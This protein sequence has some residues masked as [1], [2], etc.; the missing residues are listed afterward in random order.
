VFLGAAWAVLAATAAGEQDLAQVEFVL[1]DVGSDV[2]EGFTVN[3]SALHP[4]VDIVEVSSTVEGDDVVFSMGLR[5]D[6]VADNDSYEYSW[7]VCLD[8]VDWSTPLSC[9]DIRV[10]FT[11]GSATLE[12]SGAPVD[13]TVVAS[14]G[15]ALKVSAPLALFANFTS[16]WQLA[17]NTL[18]TDGG[19]WTD[20]ATLSVG[21]GELLPGDVSADASPYGAPT[22]AISSVEVLGEGNHYRV[23]V[24]GTTAGPVAHLLV[25]LGD[26]MEASGI[27][28]WSWSGWW[29]EQGASEMDSSATLEKVAGSW[30][31]WR[32]TYDYDPLAYTSGIVDSATVEVRALAAD[33]SW[34]HADRVCACGTPTGPIPPADGGDNGGGSEGGA[35]IPGSGAAMVAVAVAVAAALVALGTRRRD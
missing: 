29:M 7:D 4:E 10:V 22:V 15:R 26:R 35:F 28:I 18:L 23:V 6:V 11:N 16:H 21:N 17:G 19:F 33:G 2:N 20:T 30:A 1:P 13:I 8:A 14:T 31:S 3:R 24:E 9:P 25:G 27:T 32:F 5:G 12:E 34:G